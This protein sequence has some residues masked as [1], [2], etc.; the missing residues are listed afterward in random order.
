MKTISRKKLIKNFGIAVIPK[1]MNFI[2]MNLDCTDWVGGATDENQRISRF[3][4]SKPNYPNYEWYKIT[5]RPTRK[6]LKA[7]LKEIHADAYNLNLENKQLKDSFQKKADAMHKI[8]KEMSDEINA[9]KARLERV[10]Y[11]SKL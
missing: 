3:Q 1:H 8:K 7:E 5:D 2:F 4:N 11:Y 10:N 9:L 6:E